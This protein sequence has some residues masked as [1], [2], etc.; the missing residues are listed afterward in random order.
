MNK[1]VQLG[2]LCDISAGWGDAQLAA[3]HPD[4]AALRSVERV[5]S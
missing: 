2:V 4:H 3:D 5:A 1:H